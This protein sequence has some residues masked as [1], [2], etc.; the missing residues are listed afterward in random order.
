[1]RG[2][3]GLVYIII[4][5]IISKET[6]VNRSQSL[7]QA[8]RQFLHS[9]LQA[10]RATATI[11]VP[12]IHTR[13]PFS[14]PIHPTHATILHVSPA[15]PPLLPTNSPRDLDVRYCKQKQLKQKLIQKISLVERKMD[16]LGNKVGHGHIDEYGNPISGHGTT[17]YAD[18]H[19]TGGYGAEHG[20]G[21]QQ[22]HGHGTAG[23][24][25]QHHTGGYGAGHADQHHT[26]G[27]GTEH[28]TGA[29]QLHG[30]GLTPGVLRRSGS[31][32]S[33]SSSEDDGL[34][35]RRKKNKGIKDKIKEKLP[36]GHKDNQNPQQHY[37]QGVAAA[38]VQTQ[39][40]EKKG[41][42]EKIK[43]KLPGSHSH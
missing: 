37:D 23:H 17:G 8:R 7:S 19:H 25:D 41:I 43:E 39:E 18:H 20:T 38:G 28:G 21:A 40:T 9:H 5:E 34:G 3:T 33:S 22:L 13:R 1:M 31:S 29:Q 16:P 14:H 10:N 11:P 2:P 27:F 24:V 30:G 6:T 26:G 15:P 32:S 12:Q 36:G 42:M 35:G 4:V